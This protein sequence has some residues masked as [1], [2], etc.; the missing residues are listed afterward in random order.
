MRPL[1]YA[2]QYAPPALKRAWLA[3]VVVL[4]A[5][6]AN[7]SEFYTLKGHGGPVMDIAVS[8][9]TGKVATAS[10][11]NSVGLWTGRSPAWL[12]QHDAAVNVVK[13]IDE[14]RVVS[15][16]DDFSLILWDLET[17]K[18]RR[19]T[20]H[21]GKVAGLA[22]SLK[23]KLV[24]S[25]SWDGSIGLWPLAGGRPVFL[26]GH[27]AGVNDV[28]FSPDGQRL[29]SV[30]VDG[31]IRLWDVEENSEKRLLLR[32]GFGVNTIVLDSGE[33]WLAYGSVDGVTR[34]VDPQTMAQI[35]DFTL[36]RR[37][38]LAMGHHEET[39]KLAVSDGQGYI[40]VIDTK[41][42]TV[43]HDFKAVLRGPI[44]ALAF[45]GDGSSIL[46]GGIES[47]VYSWPLANLARYEPV[48]RAT[49]AFLADP[50]KMGNG[51][52]Q[53]M[54]KCSICHTL[55][56]DGG[57]KAGPTLHGLFGREA[58]SVE[59]YNY[60]PTL[61]DTDIIWNDDTI[62]R[63]FDLGP[64]HFIPGSKMPM[65]RIT[66][67]QDRTDLIEFLRQETVEGKE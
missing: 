30:S 39:G 43:A 35:A 14:R 15:A 4:A 32:H 45:S 27:S 34:I 52:R 65:Q 8:P 56:A 29:Y 55:A 1:R 58:G 12:E 10:F 44:W 41:D 21:K 63:L 25:A 53:F 3:F 17:G 9:V 2:H 42:W 20:G 66:A 7:G 46:A 11:D 54:R 5:A 67:E 18:G 19:L 22:V 60:S 47:I 51:Q 24:A 6:S 26:K 50:D 13:F 33:Q 36:D 40:S 64:D 57:R 61:A 59:G 23:K 37:P 49:P 38:I 16:G 62:D 28:A 31:T 48:A